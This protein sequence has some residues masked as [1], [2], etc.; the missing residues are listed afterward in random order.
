MPTDFNINSHVDFIAR[1]G[2]QLLRYPSLPCPCG[3]TVDG[4]RSRF[5]CPL[6]KGTGVRYE[7]ATTLTGIITGIAREKMLLEAGIAQPGDAV[8]GLSPLETQMVTDWDMVEPANWTQGQPYSGELV[9]RGSGA[10][11]T[12]VYKAK[13]VLNCHSVHPTTFV[14]TNYAVGT[15]FTVANDVVTW[16]VGRPQPAADAIYSIKYAAIFSYIV[17]TIPQ[18]R[19]DAEIS[20]GLKALL[21]PRHIAIQKRAA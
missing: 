16:I 8:L 1:H 7:T 6:C 15:D 12:L 2:A 19:Y 20:L 3:S 9:Q 11:D 21:R 17:F 10:T 5:V 13:Q 4:A 14:I 18:D